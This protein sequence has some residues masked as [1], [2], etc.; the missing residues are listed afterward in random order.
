MISF[1]CSPYSTEWCGPNSL[2][3]YE[4]IDYPTFIR[5]IR[6]FVSYGRTLDPRG[7]CFIFVVLTFNPQTFFI[8]MPKKK[9]K[10]VHTME[11]R[12]CCV[13]IVSRKKNRIFRRMFVME[14]YARLNPS[15]C[16]RFKRRREKQLH[17]HAFFGVVS[18][19]HVGRLSHTSTRF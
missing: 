8:Q 1:F 19:K 13:S 9:K 4:V 17:F 2:T 7:K 5:A 6:G 15:N 11:N 12:L 3:F 16:Q 18:R 14:R 10:R